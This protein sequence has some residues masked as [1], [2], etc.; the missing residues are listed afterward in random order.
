MTNK[1]T[2]AIIGAGGKMGGRI[3][4]NLLKQDYNLLFCDNGEKG[5]AVLKEKGLSNTPM[6]EAVPAADVV[7]MALPDAK[8]GGISK[9]LVPMM[10]PDA[11]AVVLDPAAAFAGELVTR[12]DC[13]FVV[14]HPCH[15]QLFS[16]QDSD[17]ARAD[18]F[19]G[20][21]AKQDIVIALHTGKEENFKVA[22]KVCKKMFAPVENCHRITV[23]QMAFLEPAAAE[24][25]AASAA[26]IMKESL[27]EA[28]KYG[29]PE[30]AAKAFLLGHIQIPLAIVFGA[31]SSP[32]SD[33]A[34]I[35][36][37]CGYDLIY[38]EDWK[39]VFEPE[40]VK[41][42]VQKMLHPEE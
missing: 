12:E 20:I 39:K 29:V 18:Y 16:K 24:V 23:D 41:A 14:T 37:K 26:C 27:D 25:V 5:Q 38:K 42:T 15:P 13:T 7:I 34:K 31:V 3:T 21:H 6:E 22:E 2:V 35:A 8:V 4:N 17:E 30:A 10:R 1:L 33:A 40:V 32:F 11:T 19:G 36:I 9:T 28:I